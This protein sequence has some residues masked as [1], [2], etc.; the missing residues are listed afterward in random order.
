LTNS[1][2]YWTN[3][4]NLKVDNYEIPKKLYYSVSS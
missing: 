4:A 2:K 3:V 1:K